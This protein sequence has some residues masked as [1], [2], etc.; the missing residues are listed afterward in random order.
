M[1]TNLVIKKRIPL[2]KWIASLDYTKDSPQT[3]LVAVANMV[4]RVDFAGKIYWA[5]E[6]QGSITK[7]RLGTYQ[8][9]QIVI[10]GGFDYF[11]NYLDL[12]EGTPTFPRYPLKEPL[13]SLELFPSGDTLIVCAG[14]TSAILKPPERQSVWTK[15]FTKP[16]KCAQTA[17]EAFFIGDLE[18]T[19]RKFTLQGTE[20]WEKHFGSS[21]QVITMLS[22]DILVG[23]ASG[24]VIC[25]SSEGEENWQINLKKPI[26]SLNHFQI[27]PRETK[28]LL[29][30]TL[31]GKVFLLDEEGNLIT[32]LDVKS[33]IYCAQFN[34][35]NPSEYS[36]LIGTND[37]ELLLL[38][39]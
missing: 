27:S 6:T 32:E 23:F 38:T 25:L 31:E 33:P 14:R 20:I 10:C 39:M 28:Y 19:V 5:F 9:K 37:G 12:H 7:C 13:Y 17:K 2:Q 36:F 22:K 29:I 16:L 34:I 26:S 24:Q 21:P 11:L 1:K 8:D 18:G 30:T 15:T 35:A 3:A 4:M